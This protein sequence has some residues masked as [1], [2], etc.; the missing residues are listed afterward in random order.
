M[1]RCARDTMSVFP[2]RNGDRLCG[3]AEQDGAL[4]RGADAA[5]IGID[6]RRPFVGLDHRGP[7]FDRFEP[8]LEM[9]KVG[10]VLTLALPWHHPGITRHVGN[11]IIAGEEWPVGEPLVH[12]AVQPID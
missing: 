9:R 8:A 6:L 7:R 12:Y 4:L 3:L 10:D 1:L 11:R 5:L 2:R